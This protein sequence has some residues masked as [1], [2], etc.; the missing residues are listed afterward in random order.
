MFQ[1]PSPSITMEFQ[2]GEPSLPFQ[3]LKKAVKRTVELNQEH[4]KQIT[5]VLCTNSIN[6]TEEILH[7][8]KEYNILISTSLDGPA[9]IHNHNRGKTDSY[10]RVIEGINKVRNYLGADKVSALMTTSEL[11][12]NHPKEIV[13]NYILNGFNNIFLRP[14]NPYGLAL[15]STNW[16]IYFDKFFEFYKQALNL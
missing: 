7:L 4:R 2:G 13:D 12:I 3:L 5:Y 16:N 10:N 8:C 15:N 14:L 1:S 11:S 6:L 9:F